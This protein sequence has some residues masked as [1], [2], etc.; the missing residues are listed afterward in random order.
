MP[1]VGCGSSSACYSTL[2]CFFLQFEG[3]NA[4]L[5][6]MNPYIKEAFGKFKSVLEHF[7]LASV[8]SLSPF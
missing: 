2:A 3:E 4:A 8:S 7:S 5:S 1:T 6:S